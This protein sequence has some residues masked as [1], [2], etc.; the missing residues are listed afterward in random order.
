MAHPCNYWLERC[1]ESEPNDHTISFKS[2]YMIFC[3]LKDFLS[4]L[5]HP[6]TTSNSS[7]HH[8]TRS[9]L[10]INHVAMSTP[11]TRPRFWKPGTIAPGSTVS[12]ERETSTD[13]DADFSVTAAA[14]AAAVNATTT[15]TSSLASKHSRLLLPIAAHRRQLLWALERHRV[16]IVEG[17]T[18]SGK[19][20]QLPQY[21]LDAGWA[22]GGRRIAV[23]QPRRVAACTLAARVA[24]ERGGS[25]SAGKLGGEVG[26][27]VRFDDCTSESETRLVYLTDGMLLRQLLI[28][29]LLSRYSVICI[30]E[31]HERSANTDLLLGI[32][33]KL[34]KRRLD[35]RLIISSATL[36]A[37]RFHAYF[38][39]TMEDG[40]DSA[41]I[42]SVAGRQYPVD[43]FYSNTP[44]ADYLRA[45]VDTVMHIARTQKAGDVLVFLTGREEIERVQTMLNDEQVESGGGALNGGD[46]L[47]LPLY[48]GLSADRQLDVF[49]PAPYNKRKVIL[50]TNVAE[51]SVTIDGIVYVVD[52]GYA[53]QR[54]YN[55]LTNTSHLHVTPISQQS[56]KQRAGRC[57]RTQRGVCYRLYTESAFHTLLPARS[58]PE[59]QRCNLIP[60]LLQL[61]ALGIDHSLDFPFLDP[62]PLRL[63]SKAVEMMFS[64][65]AL[66][67]E[68][69]LTGRVGRMMSELPLDP[70]L[71]RMLLYSAGVETQH[72]DAALHDQHASKQPS[73][74]NT[75]ASSSSSA[76]SSSSSVLCSEEILSIVS[77]LS[78]DN[79]FLTPPH[80]RAQADRQRLHF[81]VY[82]GD[83]LTL[84]NIFRAFM[85]KRHDQ[86]AQWAH[87]HYFNIKA[88]A[89]A[90]DIRKQL[91]RFLVR[92]KL[93]IVSA[94]N[95]TVAIRKAVLSGCFMNA[96]QLQPDG[97]YRP[98]RAS[99][100][101]ATLDTL[102]IHPSSVL[103]STSQSAVKPPFIIFHELHTSN[104]QYMRDITVIEPD[105]LT[106][107]A[108][109][110]YTF[111]T[112]FEEATK[113]YEAVL[114]AAEADES[115]RMDA[116]ETDGVRGEP[117]KKHRKL[118]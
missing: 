56:A 35:L 55:P 77:M 46:L 73:A 53:K 110:Y 36:D 117:G 66:D 23:T 85:A 79:L 78:V 111:K 74:T 52:C 3:R 15:T 17:A 115:E 61:K 89:R 113:R 68:A 26:Y 98:L 87:R 105:W 31:A 30:D 20:T 51:A 32:L 14:V 18:G 29:P 39:E 22:D 70:I 25:G 7:F 1:H 112:G 104:K 48:A 88:L 64:L 54:H 13:P 99:H 58:V 83:H 24:E 42:I 96:A 95:N 38:N 2:R 5:H 45:S 114:A 19:S 28:D 49:S 118:F 4:I 57:G 12:V 33:R 72:D 100:P 107:I 102:H 71:A 75:A 69:R 93:P 43:I 80:A 101:N 97:S 8:I 6:Q 94:G 62:P 44:V 60:V 90:W 86:P 11:S 81:A 65:G 41:V 34:L 59:L 21:L 92:F 37:E 27:M 9:F 82:E 67:A 116:A 50:S 109:H 76:C 108:P 47:V 16:L 103:A 84:L 91:K 106:E 40:S 10:A 63:V